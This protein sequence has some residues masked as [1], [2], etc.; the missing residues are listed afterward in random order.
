VG[1]FQ[2]PMA[3]AGPISIRGICMNSKHCTVLAAIAVIF[4]LTSCS[5]TKQVVCTQNCGSGSTLNLTLSDT[6]PTGVTVL[7]FTLPISGISLTPSTGSAVSVYSGGT[8]E[9]TR[10]QPDTSGV[11]VNTSVPA[12]SYTAINVNVGTSSGVFIN[13]SGSSITSSAGTCAN[14]AVCALPAGA[15][16]QFTIPVNL[17]FS[18]GGSS[19]WLGLDFNL[20]N[21]I[22]TSGGITVDFAQ[23]NV[24]KVLTTPPTGIAS[25]HTANIDDF[26]GAVTDIS[27][28]SITVTST[29]R[30][31]LTAAISSSTSVFDPQGLC[32]ATAAISCIKTGEVIGLQGVLSTAGTITASSLDVIETASSPADEVEGTIYGSS[33]NGSGTFG[34]ILSDSTI[35]SGS[36]PLASAKFG[37]VVCLTVSPTA[38]F[39]IDTGILTGQAGVPTAVG[40]NSSSD[41][42][43]GQTV[44][45]KLTGAAT[46][47]NAINATATALIL[48]FSRLTAT[49]G[50]GGA[51]N[52]TIS[53]LPA[54]ITAFTGSPQVATYTNATLFEGVS[55]G[56]NL[57]NGDSVSISA[58]MLNGVTP[59]FQAAKVRKH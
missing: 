27:S 55:G 41:I 44:R 12:G 45:A 8:F 58:L 43:A 57:T 2:P 48:R 53:G 56:S 4:A 51:T 36:S 31:N 3:S 39:V 37:Q 16:H 11:T 19:Q 25:G 23:S 21:A 30:G 47:T 34:L 20:N 24:L 50:T 46:G 33:C 28:S 52:F 18:S 54:Y 38:T 17:T 6:P 59:P 32:G 7:S 1:E 13:S 14:G 29:V 5:G 40:F 49:V 42:L 10:L 22:T 35:F 15:A 26:T 9:L